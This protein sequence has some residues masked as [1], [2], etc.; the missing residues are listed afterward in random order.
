MDEQKIH[1]ILMDALKAANAKCDSDGST[2]WIDA[3]GDRTFAVC[4]NEC[5]PD[6]YGKSEEDKR[7]YSV[8]LHATFAGSFDVKA[9][10]ESEAEEIVRDRFTNEDIK[11]SD[12]YLDTTEV[13]ATEVD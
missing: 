9:S 2:I 6:D 5:A 13:N 1:N 4:V 7:T 3:G 10:S 8:S 11:V 12:L